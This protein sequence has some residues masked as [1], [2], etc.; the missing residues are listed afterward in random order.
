MEINDNDEE[1]L[2]RMSEDENMDRKVGIDDEVERREGKEGEV[3]DKNEIIEK[4]IMMRIEM[5]KREG[6]VFWGMGIE[7]RKCDEM[8]EEE[9]KKKWIGFKDFWWLKID[10]GGCI[11][12]IE[13][14]E[15]EV[16][17]IDEREIIEKIK[18][19]RILRIVVEDRRGEKD[20]MREEEWEGKV[21]KGGIERNE[22]E[23][24]L[25]EFE[26]IGVSEKNEGKEERMGWVGGRNG[27]D[28][29][30]DRMVDGIWRNGRLSDGLSI[31]LNRKK[32][33]KKERF[34]VSKKR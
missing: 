26:R 8:I 33:E 13:I 6:E 20:R 4:C 14:V 22:K 10:G 31:I 9:S 30:S 25:R 18:I 29:G 27:K 16:E 7:K 5:K 11:G 17:I 23:K 15:K 34:Y 32:E 3:V 21:G 1:I 2:R 19:E 12:V 24:W 28:E